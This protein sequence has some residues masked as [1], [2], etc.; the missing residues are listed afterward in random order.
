MPKLLVDD[1][2]TEGGCFTGP[3]RI[4]CLARADATS[5]GGVCLSP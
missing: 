4:P 2:R 5:D 3:L 1:P